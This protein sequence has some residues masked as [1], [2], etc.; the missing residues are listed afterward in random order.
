[1]AQDAQKIHVGAAR[2]FLG[3][4]GTAVPPTSSDPPTLSVH[5][6]GVPSTPQ[7]GFVEVGHTFEDTVFEYTPEILDIES[8]QVFGIVD[9][10]VISQGGKLTF[11][12]QE[13]TYATLRAAFGGIGSVDD[14]DKTLFYAGGVFAMQ[15]QV[16]ML[17]SPRRDNPAKFEVLTI[18][19]AQSVEGV[20]LPYSRKTPS[21]YAVTLRAVHDASRVVGDQ[22]F[23]WFREKDAV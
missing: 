18:Y 9:T 15:S 5:T 2:I 11:T 1:M 23:Q 21:R 8:E 10:A 3:P 17:T 12:A 16:V 14:T 22:L 7:V 6:A 19:R 20:K 13:R 4:V